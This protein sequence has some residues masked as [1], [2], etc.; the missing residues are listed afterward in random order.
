MTQRGPARGRNS[1]TIP[2]TTSSPSSS[3]LY[4][5]SVATASTA[6]CPNTPVNCRRGLPTTTTTAP[7]QHKHLSRT[8]SNPE[9]M[10]K[11]VSLASPKIVETEIWKKEIY[12]KVVE[13]VKEYNHKPKLC[14]SGSL[15]NIPNFI[16]SM[17]I[18]VVPSQT[19]TFPQQSR[20]QTREHEQ[21]IL[22]LCDDII[23]EMKVKKSEA[24]AP[25]EISVD[26]TDDENHIY[27]KINKVRIKNNPQSD[28]FISTK[29]V[30]ILSDSDEPEYDY[31]KINWKKKEEAPINSNNTGGYFENQMQQAKKDS[32]A[33]SACIGYFE[34]QVL[35]SREN[36]FSRHR[37]EYCEDKVAKSK[38]NLDTKNSPVGYFENQVIQSREN[39]YSKNFE[40]Q[41][42]RPKEN[43]F[44]KNSAAGYFENL[45]NILE[46]AVKDISR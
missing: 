43:S 14:K 40:N 16:T 44:L 37:V 20:K 33:E 9:K 1:S 5:S 26:V 13:E 42:E 10:P 11:L 15:P 23:E 39:S 8:N 34:H 4:T 29:N 7:A 21:E 17:E 41:V 25:V 3:H 35:Q 31:P 30:T 46:E 36:C 32:D 12:K 6:S 24:L 22:K 18:Q 38:Q 2:T 28:K 45:V 27:G 19:L